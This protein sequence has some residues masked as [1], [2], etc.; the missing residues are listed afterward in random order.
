MHNKSAEVAFS[1]FFNTFNQLYDKYFPIVTKKV[2]KK[3]ILKPWITSKMIEN[4]K[5]K[6]NLAGL[7]KKGKIDKKNVYRF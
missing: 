4:I 7:A 2:T 5:R 1:S 6:H 3:N